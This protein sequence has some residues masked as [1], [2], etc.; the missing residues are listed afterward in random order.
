MILYFDCEE[1][2]L[3]TIENCAPF[4]EKIY[5]SYSPKP[6]KKYNNN[7]PV[8]Y[9]NN[10]KL[11]ILYSSKFFFKIDIISGLWESEEQQREECRL[12]AISDGYDYL[13]IQD[14]DEF[15]LPN[16]YQKNINQILCNPDYAVYQCPWITFWKNVNTIIL[17]KKKFKNIHK[18]LSLNPLFAINL[19]Y[20]NQFSNRRLVN[21]LRNNL[22][23]SG[24]C[25]HFSY[26]LSNEQVL[27]KIDTWGHSNQ[28]N[29]YWYK[30]KWLSW[31]FDTKNICPFI[32]VDW[33]R[34]EMYVSDLPIEIKDYVVH[35]NLIYKL[36]IYQ[37]IHSK[38]IDIK[39]LYIY[40]L[41]LLKQRL[42][43]IFYKFSN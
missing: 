33:E 1:F 37:K 10:S 42:L 24:I 23:L 11:E 9:D 27:K 26:V 28:V 22:L 32:S 25:F 4:V 17:H 38:I 5:I 8:L 19:K 31:E 16:E 41:N 18:H 12:K 21:D 35:N 6:W 2:I 43:E 13:I 29:K 36:S 14:A 40:N 34:A 30:Y 20:E 39:F 3:K 7:A 15:Y